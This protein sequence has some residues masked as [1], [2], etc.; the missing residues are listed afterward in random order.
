[1][2]FLV[3]LLFVACFG[4]TVQAETLRVC[5]SGCTHSTVEAA[6]QAASNGDVIE[7]EAGQTFVENLKV[8]AKSGIT[9]RS[10]RWRELPDL[11]ERIDPIA[12][13]AL[14]PTIRQAVGVDKL[15]S[16]GE[17]ESAVAQNGINLDADTIRFEYA[18]GLG[19]NV[20]VACFSTQM[21]QPLVEKEKYYLRNWNASTRTAQIALEPGGPIIDLL[22]VGS[23]GVAGYY[24]RPRC[25][26]WN[27]PSDWTIRGVK[28]EAAATSTGLIYFLVNVGLN[29]QPS[30]LMGPHRIRFHQ[31][32]IT[33]QPESSLGP[34]FCLAIAAGSGHEVI[35]SW[36]DHCKAAQNL[37]SKGIWLH[38]VDDVEIRNNYISAGSINVLTAGDDAVRRE[39]VR[40][41]RIRGNF[42]EKRGYM[43]YRE[44]SGEPQGECY[45]GGGS[46]AFY[47]RTDVTPNTCANGACYSCQADKTWALDTTA[48]YRNDDYLTKN[49]LE[50]KDCDDCTVEGNVLRG[51]YVGPDSGQGPCILLS[52]GTGIGFGQGYHRLHNVQVRNNWCDDVYRG[53]GAASTTT[54]ANPPPFLQRPLR[55]IV[56]ENNLVTNL[57]RFPALSQWPSVGS[58]HIRNFYTVQASDGMKVINNT[59]RPAPGSAGRNAVIITPG[60]WP[61]DQLMRGFEMRN[62]IFHFDGQGEQGAFSISVPP[63]SSFDCSATGIL[64]FFP[65]TTDKL[66]RNNLFS[67]GTYRQGYDFI[68]SQSCQNLMF[69]A[70]EWTNQDPLF[71]SAANSRLRADSPFSG[72]NSNATLWSDEN[73]DLGADIDRLEMYTVPTLK[74]RASMPETLKLEVEAGRTQAVLRFRRPGAT[75]CQVKVYNDVARVEGNLIQDSVNS[76]RQQDNRES[77]VLDGSDVQFLVGALDP[78]GAEHRYQYKID[79]GEVWAVGWF[80]TLGN[81]AVGE[82]GIVER[83]AAG[84]QGVVEFSGDSTFSAPQTLAPVLA[85]NGQI[86]LRL[87]PNAT[88]RYVRYRILDTQGQQRKASRIWIR[89][90]R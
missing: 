75:A 67:G 16:F 65:S 80:R 61:E 1:M 59:F 42:L 3:R 58:V 72:A 79:C 31:V 17:E 44:G 89:P 85:S 76:E 2:Q 9:I 73:Q 51:A 6:L 55:N 32:I 90:A 52:V 25:T 48:N 74:G 47:R 57:G 78:L 23:A 62:N 66:V 86:T 5:S 43:M 11:S 77:S 87:P 15:L 41:V 20:P 28:L 37:E 88:G 36:I 40:N 63:A 24:E 70:N 56:I 35:S 33:G 12:H 22:S 83:A 60:H 71:V 10:S 53:I 46:G 39:V 21:P 29:Q 64:Q 54:G 13:A 26:A 38:N 18:N 19:E 49:L 69:A 50:L 81:E 34:V 8:P 68:R 30:P 84:E 14:V 27:A 82:D 7:L 45:Y 4:L